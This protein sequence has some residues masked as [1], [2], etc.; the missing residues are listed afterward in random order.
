MQLG[1]PT[2][3]DSDGGSGQI[4]VYANRIYVPAMGYNPAI[5][6]WQYKMF[7]VNSSDIIYHWLYRR[8]PNPPE[9]ID[10]RVLTY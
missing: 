5:D 6:M 7:Y 2:K 9:R 4:L 10:V 1:P 3:T 8:N